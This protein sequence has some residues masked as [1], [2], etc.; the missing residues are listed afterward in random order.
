[1]SKDTAILNA[2]ELG[3]QKEIALFDSL[4]AQVDA[5]TTKVSTLFHVLNTLEQAIESETDPKRLATLVEKAEVIQNKVD[6]IAFNNKDTAFYNELSDYFDE[7]HRSFAP[8]EIYKR[9]PDKDEK[10]FVGKRLY[11][12]VKR[13]LLG[14]LGKHEKAVVIDDQYQAE[15]DFFSKIADIKDESQF[16]TE[17]A[18][19]SEDTLEQHLLYFSTVVPR[20]MILDVRLTKSDEFN[21]FLTVYRKLAEEYV[22]RRQEKIKTALAKSQRFGYKEIN[23]IYEKAGLLENFSDSQ[24]DVDVKFLKIFMKEYLSLFN[25]L[26]LIYDMKWADFGSK[27]ARATLMRPR[28]LISN[29]QVFFRRV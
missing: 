20:T 17:I 29:L 27:V 9:H 4:L 16:D 5:R 18:E 23:R 26:Q 6:S 11:T 14:W 13:T 22:A 19:M 24:E 15:S 28:E 8:P 10:N 2:S 25:R 3:H 1:M 7:V 21:P 12:G